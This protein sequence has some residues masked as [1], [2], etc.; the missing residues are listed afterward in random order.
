[1]TVIHCIK[2]CYPLTTICAEHTF[3]YD[4]L[5]TT[6]TSEVAAV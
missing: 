4:D 3:G 2:N 1:M 6:G 5:P